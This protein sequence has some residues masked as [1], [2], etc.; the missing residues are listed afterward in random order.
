MTRRLSVTAVAAG[1]SLACTVPA[2]AQAMQHPK[3]T[4]RTISGTVVDLSCRFGQGLS[5]D[6]HRQCAQ[7]CAERGIPLAILGIDGKLYIPTSSA[8]P[9]EGQNER[10]KEFAE[11]QV[12]VTGTVFPAGGANAIQI[13]SIQRKT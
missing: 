7:V 12:T 10:L 11:Q 6:S 1:L 8:M 9:G 13:A 2:A 5:G 4:Q 3:G